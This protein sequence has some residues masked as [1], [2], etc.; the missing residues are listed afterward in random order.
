[1]KKLTRQQTMQIIYSTF[2]PTVKIARKLDIGL[3]D[4]VNLLEM[5]YYHETKK[6]NMSTNQTL[7]LLKISQSKLST[8]SRRLKTNFLI[9]SKKNNTDTDQLIKFALWAEPMS[10]SR[11]CQ[12]LKDQ[13]PTDITLALDRLLKEKEIIKEKDRT[14]TYKLTNKKVSLIDNDFITTINGLN[15]SLMSIANFIHSRFFSNS[16]KTFSRTITL[17][18]K[19]KEIPRYEN[20]NLKWRRIICRHKTLF[21]RIQSNN[22][23]RNTIP[24]LM[25][26]I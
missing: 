13:K 4:I 25:T 1:M 21:S 26:N 19:K 7:K 15:K 22:T 23:R 5:A 14:T 17:K 18:I 9:F 11:L 3:K 24:L 10:K 8:L 16:E 20:R 6:A 12:I 2:L